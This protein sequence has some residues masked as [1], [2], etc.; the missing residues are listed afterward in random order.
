ME[1]QPQTFGCGTQEV[2]RDELV[3][4]SRQRVAGERM[5][6]LSS[7]TTTGHRDIRVHRFCLQCP[8][9]PMVP[10]TNSVSHPVR[11]KARRSKPGRTSTYARNCRRTRFLCPQWRPPNRCRHC[12]CVALRLKGICGHHL[13]MVIDKFFLASGKLPLQPPC[14]RHMCRRPQRQIEQTDGA[15]TPSSQLFQHAWT[16]RNRADRAKF[17]PY[18][19]MEGT[20]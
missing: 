10:A 1:G 16:E 15:P 18:L 7:A 11:V 20:R 13:L 12:C 14:P 17:T 5:L 3:P 8:T 9:R 6:R 4:R 2:V 19:G